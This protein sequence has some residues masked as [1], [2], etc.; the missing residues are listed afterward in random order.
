M[1]IDL[2]LLSNIERKIIIK[3]TIVLL[4]KLLFSKYI[5]LGKTNSAEFIFL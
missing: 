2:L 3:N 1:I 4:E 5:L